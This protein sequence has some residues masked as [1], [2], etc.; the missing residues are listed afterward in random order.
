MSSL[1]LPSPEAQA[2]SDQLCALIHQDIARQG[3]WIPFSR[4]MELALYAPGMGYYSAG[5]RK[6]GTAGDFVTAPEISSLFGRIM[7]RQLIEIMAQSSPRIIELGAGNGKLAVDILGELERHNSLPERYDILEISAD[8]RERQQTLLQ[9]RLPHLIDRVHWLDTL[10][11][12]ISGV[13]VAN[14]VL[15]AL[16]VHLV[17]WTDANIVERGVAS[18]GENFVWQERLPENSMLLEIAQQIKVPDDTLSDVSLAARGL[19]S[20]LSERLHQGVLLFIDYG[21]GAREYYHP[22]RTQGTLMCHYRHHTH[23]DPFFLPGLQDITAHV[24][25]TAVAEAAIDAGLHLYGYTTQAY[26]LINSGITDL[27]AETD[28]ENIRDYF[29]LSAQLQKLTSPAEM[30]E[31]FKIIALGKGVDIPLCGFVSGDKSRLL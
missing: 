17:R 26:F 12:S 19:V 1:P 30:G 2:H 5:A 4:F 18:T 10:P 23:D 22:Q 24:D 11:D 9:A 13:L 27:L 16:P 31:L 21:F 6:F 8:L 7:A 29:P 14:E 3:G 20:S 28:S 15:D 25:F